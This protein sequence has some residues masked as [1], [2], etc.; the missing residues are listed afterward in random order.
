[1]EQRLSTHATAGAGRR[2]LRLPVVIERT[3]LQRSAIYE[4]IERGDFPKPVRIG[5]RAVAWLESE[6]E[7]W[8]DRK[9]AQRQELAA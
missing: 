6:V 3:G 1:L 5:L 8:I 7:G 4:A 2:M 9:L